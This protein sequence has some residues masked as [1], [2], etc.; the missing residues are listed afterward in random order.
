MMPPAANPEFGQA[1]LQGI[2]EQLASGEPPEVRATLERLVAAGYTREGAR[3][4]IGTVLI[5]EMHKTLSR[6]QPYSNDRYIAALT[7]LPELPEDDD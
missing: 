2:D 4:L 3:Q 5:R 1:I 6:N 7:R